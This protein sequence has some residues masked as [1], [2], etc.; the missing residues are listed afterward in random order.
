[1]SCCVGIVVDSKLAD[2]SLICSN[3]KFAY[4]RNR[5]EEARQGD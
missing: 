3:S 4:E 1:M 5:S 2:N